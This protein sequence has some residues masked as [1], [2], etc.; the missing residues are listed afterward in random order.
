MHILSWEKNDNKRMALEATQFYMG[1]KKKGVLNVNVATHTSSLN[2]SVLL[3]AVQFHKCQIVFTNKAQQKYYRPAQY[4]QLH[5]VTS[6]PLK[7]SS[8]FTHLTLQPNSV[9][10]NFGMPLMVEIFCRQHP[11][12]SFI[13]ALMCNLKKTSYNWLQ[14]QFHLILLS[15]FSL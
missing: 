9:L 1:W 15:L 8:R 10:L 12:H 4:M 3:R 7:Q 13:W 11:V 2:I 5:L 14:Y 6:F